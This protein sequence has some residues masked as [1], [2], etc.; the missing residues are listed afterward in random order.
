MYVHV[1]LRRREVNNI[2]LKIDPKSPGIDEL[3]PKVRETCTS[4]GIR[5]D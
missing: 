4:I 3:V 5:N 1:R 2:F